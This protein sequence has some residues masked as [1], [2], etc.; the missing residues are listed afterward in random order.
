MFPVSN[1]SRLNIEQNTQCILKYKYL[2]SINYIVTSF[3]MCESGVARNKNSNKFV[4]DVACHKN[5]NKFVSNQM[6]WMTRN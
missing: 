1:T 2:D 3:V 5:F 6:G 4:L